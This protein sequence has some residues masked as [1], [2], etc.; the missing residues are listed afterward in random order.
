[1]MQVSEHVHALKIPF[2]VPI[3]PDVTMDRFVYAF[4]VFGQRICLIDS[5]VA[6]SERLIFKYIRHAGRSAGE[7]SLLVLTHSHPDHIGAA[8]AIR[9]VTGCTVAAHPA[10]KAWIEDV[11]LQCRQRPVPSFGMLVGG[12]VKMDREL[13]D[14]EALDLGGGLRLEVRHTPGHSAGSMSLLLQPDNVLFSGDTVPLPGDLPIWEDYVAQV[15]SVE[16]IKAIAGLQ[17]LLSSWDAPQQGE[18]I[19]QTLERSLRYLRQVQQVVHRVAGQDRDIA[20]MDLC[21]RVVAELGLPPVA[22]NPLVGRS[23][24]ACAKVIGQ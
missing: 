14:G 13:A 11:E 1:M 21:K 7:I 24:V 8:K 16:R 22:A 15:R 12:S 18:A 6:G 10:E 5:G 23:L 20:P 3:A 17:V 19:H 9:Q 4:V 2:K